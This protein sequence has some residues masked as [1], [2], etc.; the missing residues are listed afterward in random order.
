VARDL[1]VDRRVHK[2]YLFVLPLL[3]VG[4]SLAI[5]MWRHDPSWWQGI[6]H[7]IMG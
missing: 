3:V 5:Y 4:Q 2:A 6:T 1:L 7:V